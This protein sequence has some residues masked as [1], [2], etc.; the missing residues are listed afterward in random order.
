MRKHP[1]F[2]D[3]KTYAQMALLLIL[4]CRFN[5]IPLRIPGG[6]FVQIDKPVLRFIWNCRGCR[7]AKTIL[8]GTD[9]ENLQL[10]TSKLI[11][12]QQ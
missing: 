2:I 3:W 10:P 9:L 11:T 5:E 7:R 8:K 1:M 4:I 12:R 6:F